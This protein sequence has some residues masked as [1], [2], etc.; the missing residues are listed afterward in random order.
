M[1]VEDVSI[2]CPFC[3]EKQWIEVDASEGEHQ[4]L[5]QDCEVCCR[6]LRLLIHRDDRHGF[7]AEVQ[8]ADG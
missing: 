2:R 6:P 3:R 7:R 5:I 1:L 4:D 8:R